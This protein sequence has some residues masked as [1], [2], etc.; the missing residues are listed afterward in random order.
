MEYFVQFSECARLPAGEFRAPG[1][2]SHQL[3]GGVA[4]P[5]AAGTTFTDESVQAEQ[6]DCCVVQAVDA[7]CA[8]LPKSSPHFRNRKDFRHHHQVGEEGAGVT[9]ACVS[10]VRGATQPKI[11]VPLGI[12]C[13]SLAL[14]GDES[15]ARAHEV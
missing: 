3:S 1:R 11:A 7:S 2:R 9:S 6:K 8:D 5:L 13:I 15:S 12:R 10:R 14:T 4:M